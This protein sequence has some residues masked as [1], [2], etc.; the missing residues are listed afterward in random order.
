LI[1]AK[2]GREALPARFFMVDFLALVDLAGKFQ[3]QSLSNPKVA[4][5]LHNQNANGV[6]GI[7]KKGD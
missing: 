4:V 1:T 2:N 6:A 7:T 3:P 5:L